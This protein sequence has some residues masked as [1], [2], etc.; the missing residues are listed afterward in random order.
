[1]LHQLLFQVAFIII[2]HLRKVYFQLVCFI[3][4]DR[5]YM[6]SGSLIFSFGPLHSAKKYIKTQKLC[7]I[8]VTEA[9]GYY[10]A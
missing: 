7:E 5:A 4:L 6:Q 9:V 10:I 2:S 8:P 1:M 3:L